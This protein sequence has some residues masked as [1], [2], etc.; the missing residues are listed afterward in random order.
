MRAT[1][2]SKWAEERCLERPGTTNRVAYGCAPPG[3]LNKGGV[4]NRVPR[5]AQPAADTQ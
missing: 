2:G 4:V 3:G 5:L 1:C